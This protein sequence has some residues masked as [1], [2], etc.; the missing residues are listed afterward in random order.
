M[1]ATTKQVRD[2]YKAQGYEVR[3]SRDG[4]VIYQKPDGGCI[5]FEGRYVSEY[6]IIEGQVVLS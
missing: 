3:I 6:R 2:H 5:W 1:N 4:H